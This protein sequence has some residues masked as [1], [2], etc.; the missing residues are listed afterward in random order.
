MSPNPNVGTPDWQNGI[1]NAQLLLATVPGATL[2][3][4]VNVPPNA[5]SIIVITYCATRPVPA[6]VVGV[7]S[8]YSYPTNFNYVIAGGNY[9]TFTFIDASTVVDSQVIVSIYPAVQGPWY[10]YSDAASHI[11]YDPTMATL[12]Q[13][14]GAPYSGTGV[15]LFGLNGGAV[16]PLLADASG[17]LLTIDAVLELAVAALNATIPADAVQVGGSDGANLRALRTD[18]T[19]QLIPIVPSHTTSAVL[20]VNAFTQLLAALGSGNYY[21]FGVDFRNDTAAAQAISIADSG[22]NYFSTARVPAG[23]TRSVDLS[24]YKYGG[25]VNQISSSAVNTYI[26]LRYAVGP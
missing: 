4:V 22:G 17:H 23:D 13:S 24:G 6:T 26:T 1:V 18:S 16:E 15:N 21:L 5:E 10:I 11:S 20:G 25:V 7:A 2:T 8:G 12:L 3:K 19:G 9:Y 14:N